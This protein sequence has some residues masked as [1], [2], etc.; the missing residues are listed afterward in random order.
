VTRTG[1]GA[2]NAVDSGVAADT[3]PHV[4]RLIAYPITG[5]RQVDYFLDG[6]QIASTTVNVPTAVLTPLA[7]CYAAAVAA[8]ALGLD[9]WGVIPMNLA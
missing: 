9:Y 4:H 2:V 3:D 6:A 1:G 5:G 7:R 8:R